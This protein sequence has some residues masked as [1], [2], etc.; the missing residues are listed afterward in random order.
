MEEYYYVSVED[1]RVLVCPNNYS[2]L[3]KNQQTLLN[4]LSQQKPHYNKVINTFACA[5][6]QSGFISRRNPFFNSR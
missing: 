1:L 6:G 5:G 2:I 4:W 3:V